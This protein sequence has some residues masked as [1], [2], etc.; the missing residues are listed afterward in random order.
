MSRSKKKGVLSKTARAIRSLWKDETKK[1]GIEDDEA[2]CERWKKKYGMSRIPAILLVTIP[3][4]GSIFLAGTVHDCAEFPHN[5]ELINLNFPNTYINDHHLGRFSE[6]GG[7]TQ[8]HTS[9]A[10]ASLAAI[11]LMLDRMWLHIRDPR[12]T[13]VSWLHFLDQINT[14][15][16]APITADHIPYIGEIWRKGGFEEKIELC[17]EYFYKDCLEWLN[18]WFTAMG[19]DFSGKYV[20][21]DQRASGD[22]GGGYRLRGDWVAAQDKRFS[23]QPLNSPKVLLTSQ[24]DLVKCGHQAVFD[25]MM[26]FYDMPRSSFSISPPN[27]GENA[28]FRRGAV[29]SWKTELPAGYQERITALLPREWRDYFGWL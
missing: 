15:Y 7:I 18:G 9:P 20:S 11:C 17:I 24:E 10:I 14:K 19:M 27:K 1:C 3:K 29:D 8:L 12:N 4:S 26:D 22:S 2:Y 21:V 28:H 5:S 6:R 13:L 23:H 25:A 16:T